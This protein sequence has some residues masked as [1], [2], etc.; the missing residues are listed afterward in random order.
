MKNRQYVPVIIVLLVLCSMASLYGCG[1]ATSGGGGGAAAQIWTY[2][3]NDMN[4]CIHIIPPSSLEGISTIELGIFSPY[5]MT[6]SPGDKKLYVST[7]SKEVLVVD[8]A[9]NT[10]TVLAT[11]DVNS[12][13]KA[14][15]VSADGN[16]LY[17]GASN[18]KLYKIDLTKGTFTS[19]SFGSMINA[20]ALQP[21]GSE[22]YVCNGEH[23]KSYNTSYPFT[24]GLVDVNLGGNTCYDMAVK[25]GNVYAPIY[26]SSTNECVI[27]SST[28]ATT[29]I[30]GEGSMHYLFGA[31]GIP[32]TN[33]VYL[34]QNVGAGTIF[35]I[36]TLIPTTKWVSTTETDLHSPDYMA[37]TNDGKYVAIMDTYTHTQIGWMDTSTRTIPYYTTIPDSSTQTNNIVFIYK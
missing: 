8:T 13:S 19:E 17:M 31:V 3:G 32:G 4:N 14:M 21:Y 16:Y 36:N 2:V 35:I 25:D 11:L 12:A 9:S 29:I 15:R 6:K 7:S 26:S 33:E 18:N 28:D 37:V 24:P 5:Y 30:T 10:F 23:I 27:I 22:M 1:S 34:S 20:I